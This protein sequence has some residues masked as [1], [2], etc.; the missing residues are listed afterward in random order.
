MHCVSLLHGAQP[1]GARRR[2]DALAVALLLDGLFGFLGFFF[3]LLLSLVGIVGCLGRLRR[4]PVRLVGG[5][6]LRLG[7][8]L[9]QTFQLGLLGSDAV[10]F[11]LLFGLGVGLLLRQ[12]LR[13][14]RRLAER[15][16]SPALSA[17]SR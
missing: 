17:R 7:L 13:E 6:R 2:Q 15:R 1:D 5:L 3:S 16:A 12:A 4:E 10:R 8:L 14:E 11:L 9:Q